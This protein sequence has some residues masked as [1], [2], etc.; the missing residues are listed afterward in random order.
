LPV[1]RS[2]QTRR[3]GRYIAGGPIDV[4]PDGKYI[5][6]GPVDIEPEDNPNLFDS[7]ISRNSPT[8]SSSFE[9]PATTSLNPRWLSDL[10]QR[11][12]KCIMF[13][14]QKDQL[15][16]AGGILKEMARDW[17]ELVAGSEGFLTDRTRRELY[18]HSVVWGEMDSMVSSPEVL[19]LM[20]M[21]KTYELTGITF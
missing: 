4:G 21:L 15:K 16:E 10:K 17:R 11:V 6:G 9:N 7:G 12:G 2:A 8:A 5:A 1:F 19:F 18:R 3:L 13:G 20:L 14:L